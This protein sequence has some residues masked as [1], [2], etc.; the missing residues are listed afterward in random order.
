LDYI[1]ACGFIKF[2]L[3]YI[4]PPQRDH[5]IRKRFKRI[6]DLSIICQIQTIETVTG[7][8]FG[9]SE[10]VLTSTKEMHLVR[11][12]GM[13][14]QWEVDKKNIEKPGAKK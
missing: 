8:T 7:V 5:E 4:H 3:K 11:N 13:H 10:E 12:I 1:K 6:K 2:A 14:N 9:I